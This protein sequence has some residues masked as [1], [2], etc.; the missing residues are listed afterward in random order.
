MQNRISHFEGSEVWE[1]VLNF[2]SEPSNCLFALRFKVRR[3]LVFF[4]IEVNVSMPSF[5]KCL[6][7]PKSPERRESFYVNEMHLQSYLTFYES[8]Q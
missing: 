5:Y 8:I 4:G 2:G 7:N 1:I 3:F 6:S